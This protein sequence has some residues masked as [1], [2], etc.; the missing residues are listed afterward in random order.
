[1]RIKYVC[2][3]LCEL[4]FNF[5]ML[6]L[7]GF[8][9]RTTTKTLG[10]PELYV[11]L[12]FIQTQAEDDELNVIATGDF[13]YWPDRV[14]EGLKNSLRSSGYSVNLI[15]GAS[16][17]HSSYD[18]GFFHPRNQVVNLLEDEITK[19]LLSK[20]EG[21]AWVDA[22]MSDIHS[23]LI[24]KSSC[25]RRTYQIFSK[26]RTINA[27]D[28]KPLTRD[29]ANVA[30]IKYGNNQ[31]LLLIS[32]AGHPVFSQSEQTSSDFPGEIRLDLGSRLGC[33]V[34]FFQ[35]F[36]GDLRPHFLRQDDKSSFFEKLK[37]TFFK[38]YSRYDVRHFENFCSGV[39]DKI[40]DL[41]NDSNLFDIQRR[42]LS[43][44]CS[45]KSY[46]LRSENVDKRLVVKSLSFNDNQFISINAEVFSAYYQMLNHGNPFFAIS[47][48]EKLIGYL[49]TSSDIEKGGYEVVKANKNW[50]DS[51]PWSEKSIKQIE[52]EMATN[53]V[54]VR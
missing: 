17:T 10:K 19:W 45:K 18:F 54:N 36:G 30:A 7:S 13:L 48:S 26:Y 23:K 5:E 43:V 41:V 25:R 22:Q 16:H 4:D 3:N 39:S 50:N 34:M 8:G 52:E 40:F 29:V 20:F 51:L 24:E 15:C 47:C 38:L 9:S 6:H 37:S 2:L 1:M 14:Y 31:K 35:G 44:S 42:D 21:A 27:W 28:G 32:Y 46:E 53:D 49:P 11:Q 12:L 33:E